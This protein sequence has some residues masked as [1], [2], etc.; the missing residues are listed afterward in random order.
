MFV[1]NCK[2]IAAFLLSVLIAL[3]VVPFASFDAVAATPSNKPSAGITAQLGVK[4]SHKAVSASKYYQYS[5]LSST[6][7]KAYD[8][9]VKGIAKAENAIDIASYKLSQDDAFLLIQKVLADHPEY[10]YVTKEFSVTLDSKGK[11]VKEAVLLYSDGKNTDEIDKKTWKPVA[12]A[13]RKTISKQIE[14]LNKKTKEILAKISTKDSQLEKE[15][16]IY[17]YLTANIRYNYEALQNPDSATANVWNVYGA[18]IE[19]SAVCEGYAKSFVYLCRLV[20]INATTITGYADGDHMWNAVE[21][22]KSWYL[23]DVTWADDDDENLTIYQYFN[24]TS[25]ELGADHIPS[26]ELAYP[27]CT[28]TKN[29]YKTF[30]I[31]LEKNKLSSNYKS[32][33]DDV[34]KNDEAFL[35][36]YIGKDGKISIDVIRKLFTNSTSSV[37]KHLKS[38]GYHVSVGSSYM[39]YGNYMFLKVDYT[40]C[41]STCQTTT[42]PATTSKNGKIVKKCVIC[43]KAISTTTIKSVSVKSVK[44]STTAYT[45]DGK[46][47][48]PTVTVKDSAGK[49]LKKNTDYTVSYASGRKNV[50]TYKVTVKLKGKYS[51]SVVLSFKINPAKSAVSKATPASKSLKITVSKKTTQ[52][53]GYQIQ[54]ST[55]KSFK[56]AKTKTLSKNTTTSATLTGLKAKTTYYVRVRTYK[57]VGKSA[58]YS[59]WSTAKSAKTK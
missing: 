47:K 59:A 12:K 53:T 16:Y 17:D 48:T 31:D 36:L 58:Y 42:T 55:S 6:Q 25:K 45:Y 37:Q 3:T 1:V 35:P 22:D 54:Y 11:K 32:I 24:V 18:L 23:V 34:V 49:A 4:S 27:N 20:G 57:T 26:T 2:K 52:V 40:K 8:S 28:A 15:K 7:K 43:G 33:I 13:N 46:V 44:L 21:I 38:K 14:A 56:S 39:Q 41:G 5:S 10:F 30:C 51:G 29:S 19:G 50:G 9:L